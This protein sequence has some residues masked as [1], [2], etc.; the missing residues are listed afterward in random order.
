MGIDS[1]EQAWQRWSNATSFEDLC[2]LAVEFLDGDLPAFPGWMAPDIDEETDDWVPELVA[3]NERGFLTTASQPGTCPALSHDGLPWSQRAFVVGFASPALVAELR[4]QVR[5]TRL[6]LLDFALDEAGGEPMPA[7]R[8]G[9]R[10]YLFVGTG[11]GP[12]ERE[13]FAQRIGPQAMEALEETR[14][15]CLVDPVWGRDDLLWAILANDSDG[16]EYK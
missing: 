7:A 12:A 14:Y 15:V 16:G 5:G 13:V 9:D 4:D 1:R 8:H 11:E 10:E 2:A 3:A 6:R